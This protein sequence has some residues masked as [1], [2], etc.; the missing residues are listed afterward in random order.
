MQTTRRQLLA[1]TGIVGL[2]AALGFSA[3]AA[4]GGLKLVLLGNK[5]GPRV[6]AGFSNPSSVLLFNGKSYV[7]DCGYGVTRQLAA[8][9][10]QAHQVRTILITHNHSDHVLE[11]GPLI[12]NAWAGGLREEIHVWGPPPVAEIV[13]DFLQSMKYDIDIRIAD[14]GRPDLR[15]LVVVHE[16]DAPG[17][18]FE[19]D[20]LKVRTAKVRHPPI[21]QAYAY[22]FDTDA[23]SIVLSGDTTYSPELIALAQGAD[24]LVHEAMNLSGIDRLLSRNPNATT[25]RAHLL[26]SHATT[27]QVGEVAAAAGVKTVVLYHFVPGD[28]PSI[29]DDM[30][31]EGVR[32]H[33]AGE[34]IVGKELQTI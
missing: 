14:E 2:A 20:G 29:T 19:T 3:R 30:W 6:I 34:V 16:F 33:F 7:V 24:V 12:Y 4:D 21:T 1:A 32:K 15:R 18:V 31:I 9:G 11:L 28:D 23:R 25:L 13:N 27:E 8:C 26:A 10:I 5:G 22:R 17:L